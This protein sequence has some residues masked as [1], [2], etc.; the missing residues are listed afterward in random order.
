M[1]MQRKVATTGVLLLGTM[2]VTMTQQTYCTQTD[3]PQINSSLADPDR[4]R[5]STT[6]RRPRSTNRY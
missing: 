6:R 1:T 2:C 5:L 3:E 4:L